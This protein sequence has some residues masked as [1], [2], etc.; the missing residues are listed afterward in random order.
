LREDAFM[1]RSAALVVYEKVV[2]AMPGVE[3]KG[4]TM[5]YTSLNSHIFSVLHKDGSLALRLPAAERESFL[6]KYKTTLSS[7]YG[8]VQPEYVVIP[9][10]LLSRTKDLQRYFEISR[11]YVAALKPKATARSRKSPSA[12]KKTR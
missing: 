3:R 2:A 11:A 1:E 9:D 4:D 6:T 8:S 10:A 7:Q 5:P 12:R